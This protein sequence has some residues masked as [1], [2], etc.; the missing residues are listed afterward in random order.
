MT[1]ENG[2]LLKGRYRIIGILG[3]GGMGAVYRACDENLDLVVAIKENLFLTANFVRQFQQEALVIASLR[4]PN[5]P[6]VFDYF[7]IEGQ[8]QYLIMDY[9]EGED[10][11][12]WMAREK[13]VTEVEALQIGIAICDALIYLHNQEPPITHRDIKPSNIKISPFGE[14]ILVDFGLVKVLRDKNV[15]TTAVR[16]MTPGFSPPEQYGEGS[17]DHRTD[18]FSLGATL[19]TALT[20]FLPEDCLARSTGKA[21]L[22]SLRSYQ[23]H[24]SQQT[25]YVIEKALN[26]RFEDRWQSAQEFRDAL[27]KARDSLPSAKLIKT[28]L[29][30]PNPADTTAIEKP[31]INSQLSSK[32]RFKKTDPVWI[33]FGSIIL[34]LVLA[35]GVS[36]T[37]Q[38]DLIES[39]GVGY[40]QSLTVAPLVDNFEGTVSPDEQQSLLSESET[41]ESSEIVV[42]PSPT[43]FGGGRGVLAFVSERSGNPQIWLIDVT[44]KIT[45]RLTDFADGAC[46]PDWSPDGKRIV[47]TSPCAA[48]QEQYPGSRLVIIDVENKQLTPLPA[49]LEGDYDPAWSPDGE[50]IAYT[51]L[52]NRRPQ[53]AKIHL[54]DLSPIRLSDGSHPDSSPSWSPDGSQIAFVRWRNVSQIWLMD[55]DGENTIQF[56][57]SGAID[58]SKPAWTKDGSLILFSQTLG[59]GSPSKQLF[60]MRLE[61]IGQSEEYRLIPRG[62]LDYI[63]LMDNVAV[64]PDGFW[65]A[66]D[67]W[68]YDVLSDIYIMS[69]PGG[70][71]RQVTEHPAMDY[72]PAWLPRP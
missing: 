20:G 1:L 28:N 55:A 9:I 19:Y 32:L 70:G 3:Q 33:I 6:R 24:L 51:T 4:H 34:L 57:L 67:F 69:F 11:Q 30:S 71:L 43:P 8:A 16:A 41:S 36:L 46:Q 50:W 61:D 25:A 52:V 63:P 12:Q 22:S 58:N 48:K 53:V 65:L 5:L 35:L 15:T 64:S 40:Q 44:S 23:P 38:Q 72:D 62:Q 56:T 54:E 47:F 26:L 27:I 37:R 18:I 10:L 66:F 13:G 49:S 21:D 2:Y 68:F 39:F 29:D 17:T 7:V 60:G 45:T 14:I 42:Q 31:S 59:L